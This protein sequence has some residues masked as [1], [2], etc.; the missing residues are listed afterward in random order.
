MLL[1]IIPTSTSTSL[2]KAPA[3]EHEYLDALVSQMEIQ[4]RYITFIGRDRNYLRAASGC[5]RS[6]YYIDISSLNFLDP[7]LLHRCQLM[8]IE[9]RFFY[10]FAVTP[11]MQ[12]TPDMQVIRTARVNQI[13]GQ[14]RLF[15]VLDASGG[16]QCSRAPLRP[17]DVNTATVVGLRLQLV[18]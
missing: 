7:L 15:L 1:H 14:N 16:F 18:F 17:E 4:T 8:N 3:R 13:V 2:R 9:L 12:V 11:R 6:G 10:N 5:I